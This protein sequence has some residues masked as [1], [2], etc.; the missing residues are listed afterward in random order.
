M[1][2]APAPATV[3]VVDDDATVRDVVRR[4]LERAGHRVVL[5]SDGNDA[6]HQVSEADP[7]LVILDIMLPG[8]DGFTV[9]RT[10][11][12][13]SEV[14]V[15]ML[16]ALGEAED[17]IAGLALG[18]DDY[19]AKPF[20][21]RELALRAESVLRRSRIQLTTRGPRVLRDGS[22]HLDLSA[23]S[24]QIDGHELGLT[25]REFDLLAFFLNHT[26]QAFDRVQLLER[27]WGWSFGDQS[28]VTVHVRRLREKIEPRP[29]APK[30]I[31]TVWGVGYRFDAE[32]AAPTDSVAGAPGP[33]GDSDVD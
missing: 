12:E 3:L 2:V 27:V 15:I 8:A 29:A 25:S 1:T 21:P 18:A 10:L 26:G 17:R 23:R 9:C 32:Q 7:D 14:P 31:T 5:A 30:R 6:L 20:S 4:Y 19:V 16:T 11:R 28:T 13:S 24:A 22:L 33:E